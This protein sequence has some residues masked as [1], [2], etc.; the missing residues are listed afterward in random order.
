LKFQQST[1]DGLRRQNDDLVGQL[2]AANEMQTMYDEELKQQKAR[3]LTLEKALASLR[4]E[5]SG[6]LG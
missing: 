2:R 5:K 1:I 4:V 6:N 3:V